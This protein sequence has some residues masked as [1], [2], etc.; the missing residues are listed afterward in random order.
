MS[1]Y[2]EDSRTIGTNY[3]TKESGQSILVIVVYD[4]IK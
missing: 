2:Y 3:L 1:M 4:V